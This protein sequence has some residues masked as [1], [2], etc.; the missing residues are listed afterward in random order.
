M[1]DFLAAAFGFPAVLFT[2]LLVLVAGYWLLVVFGVLGADGADGADLGADGGPDGGVD[3]G[4]FLSSF[5][6]G[7]VPVT[8][9]LSLLVAV[10]WFVSLAGTGLLNDLG[11]GTL[12]RV[13]IALVVLLVAVVAGGLAARLL[14]RPLRPLFAGAENTTRSAFVGRLCVIRTG[15]VTTDFGQAEVTAADGSSA[16]VQVRQSGD[17][18]LTAG[19]T[20]LIYDYDADGEFF[21]VT[22]VDAALDP[23]HPSP[24]V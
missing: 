3:S 6:F 18:P 4:G 5:G 22:P 8:V 23:D 16:I 19:S 10:G 11:V 17:A 14:V 24:R 15:R 21:R 7:G 20:A 2:F 9:V 12:A 13:G 1:D